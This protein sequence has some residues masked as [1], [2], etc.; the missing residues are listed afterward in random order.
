M[1]QYSA[2]ND[3]SSRPGHSERN[4]K[5]ISFSV[6]LL[7]C[8]V[9]VSPRSLQTSQWCWGSGWCCPAWSSTT[10]ASSSGPRTAWLLESERVFEVRVGKEI[11]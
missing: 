8:G 10:V 3:G 7:Q 1:A 4:L 6:L 9:C 5:L 2:I 11:L